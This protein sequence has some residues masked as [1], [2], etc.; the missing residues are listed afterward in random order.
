MVNSYLQFS[1]LKRQLMKNRGGLI[2]VCFLIAFH[3]FGLYKAINAIVLSNRSL[4]W[5]SVEAEIVSS[6]VYSCPRI[7]SEDV[8][9]EYC[10]DLLYKYSVN[11]R[12]YEGSKIWFGT[13]SFGVEE[14]A[15]SKSTMY[16][17]GKRVQVFYDSLNPSLACLEPGKQ[18]GWEIFFLVYFILL[19]PF[20]LNLLFRTLRS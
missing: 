2:A 5:P 14:A 7:V 16:S 6:Y 19:L 11:G 12:M 8:W 20:F 10:V 3:L 15:K 9:Q 18:S 1:T 17:V 13:E 4:T